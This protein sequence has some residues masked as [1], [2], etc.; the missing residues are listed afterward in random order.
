MKAYSL[1]KIGEEYFEAL[2]DLEP[3]P[4]TAI[5]HTELISMPVIDTTIIISE[6]D[7]NKNI[8]KHRSGELLDEQCQE[9]KLTLLLHPNP[10][11]H[12]CD[13]NKQKKYQLNLSI[14]I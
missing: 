14:M 3:F 9:C 5:I 13:L 2:E 4:P 12:Y 1:S 6:E 7:L 11:K 10:K 8:D